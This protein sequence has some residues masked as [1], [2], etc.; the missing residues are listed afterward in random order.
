MSKSK[1]AFLSV[2]MQQTKSE[3]DLAQLTQSGESKSKSNYL[4][5]T[6]ANTDSTKSGSV[7]AT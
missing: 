3:P 6:K 1:S 4:S 5:A 2:N 7:S